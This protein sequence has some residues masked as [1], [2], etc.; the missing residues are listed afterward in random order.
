MASRKKTQQAAADAPSLDK[1]KNLTHDLLLAG[2]GAWVTSRDRKQGEKDGKGKKGEKDE[3]G[4]PDFATLVSEG[5]KA[6]PG[7]KAS[8][9]KTWDEWKEKSQNLGAGDRLAQGG[10]RLRGAFDERVSSAIGGLGLPTRKEVE[11]LEA[12]VDRLLGARA[13][14]RRAAA[15]KAA[16]PRKPA[17]KKVATKKAAKKAA[18]ARRATSKGSR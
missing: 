9:Q 7:L 18:P 16:A 11:A 1:I 6:E 2:I 17:A 12:K 15:K 13:P 5:R 4:L 10:S 3:K 8:M 14:A